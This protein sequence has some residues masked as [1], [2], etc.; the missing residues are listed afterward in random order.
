MILGRRQL[1]GL[2]AS[3]IVCLA[4]LAG[5]PTAGADSFCVVPA[6]GCAHSEPSVAAALTA[7]SSGS[8]NTI[9]LGAATYSEDNLKYE[10]PGALAIEGAGPGATTIQRASTGNDTAVLTLNSAARVDLSGVG[11]H[12][13]GGTGLEGLNAAGPGGTLS[14]IAVDVAA[15]AENSAGVDL[16]GSGWSL[17]GSTIDLPKDDCVYVSASEVSLSQDTLR[18]C[19]TAVNAQ[20]GSFTAQR[21]EISG[22]RIGVDLGDGQGRLEDS[23]VTGATEGIE[24]ALSAVGTLVAKQDTLIGK[25]VGEG[26]EGAVCFNHTT[27][28][29]GGGLRLEDSIVRGFAHSL[30]S[31]ALPGKPCAIVAAYDDY[32]EGTAERVGEGT[33]ASEHQV[34]VDPRFV[35]EAAGNYRLSASSP[36]L[37]F[38]ARPLEGIESPTDLDGAPRISGGARDLGAYELQQPPITKGAPPARSY[39][40]A[41]RIV[42]VKHG[43]ALLE[44]HCHGTVACLGKVKL[45]AKGRTIGKAKF[46]VPA[47][48]TVTVPVKLSAKG[49]AL[50]SNAGRHG[51]KAKLRGEGVVARGVVLKP[52]HHR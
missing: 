12:E 9:R 26:G 39:A 17:V 21:L 38:D 50:V 19:N 33:I 49:L 43:K 52:H 6:S 36:V 42:A 10:G 40:T 44:L 37:N 15:G 13:S 23:L 18:S 1:A 29:P 27:S 25:G 32:D 4:M 5:P 11:L 47:S 28:S 48:K 24:V 2:C 16:Q 22:V 3:L 8:S 30:V 45:I 46:D 7:A 41:A 35:D 14:D 34:N 20:F 51:F 31:D